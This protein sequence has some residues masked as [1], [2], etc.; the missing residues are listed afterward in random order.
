MTIK[1]ILALLL[2]LALFLQCSRKTGPAQMS[3]K[4]G[5]AI[6]ETDRMISIR[7]LVEI[8][9]ETVF[10]KEVTIYPGAFISTHT[11]GKVIF[12]KR[13]NIIGDSQVFEAESDIE[14][15]SNTLGTINVGWF[16]AK[17]DDSEDDTKAFQ[18]ALELASV[19]NNSVTIFVP[20]GQYYIKQTLVI[21]NR[22]PINK[23]INLVGEAMSSSTNQ[24][25]S[26][27]WNG[28]PGESMILMRNNYLNF[29]QYIDFASEYKCE[30]KSNIVLRYQIYQMEFRDCSFSGC[31]G[32]GSSNIDL[33]AGNSDQVSEISFINCIFRGKTYDNTTWQT[34]AAVK[35]GKANTKDIYFE[36][37]S[38]LGYNESAINIEISEVLYVSNSTFAHNQTDIICLLCGAL[39][40]SNYSEQSKSFYRSTV[41]T[42]LAFTTMIN[43]YFDGCPSED[44]V[45]TNGAG[46]L[47]L[48]NNNFGGSGGL[49][50]VNL[51]RWDNKNISSIYSMGNYFRNHSAVH[52]PFVIEGPGPERSGFVQSYGDK[53]GKDG[54]DCRQIISPK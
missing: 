50:S 42:N 1:T 5:E 31:A 14:M 4:G 22:I 32:L 45:I 13:L 27:I 28:P 51:I 53:M 54:L 52:S 11:N 7:G 24:G 37:C 29:V 3:S 44:Y 39:L 33:N 20:T 34:S 19:F 2:V 8:E 21:E 41:S 48:I 40:T 17:G 16:G 26:L 46:S 6:V 9:H 30:L 43:N 47:V 10:D 38:F 35:G 23:S 15:K 49:D 36:K 25:S 12:N 18:K